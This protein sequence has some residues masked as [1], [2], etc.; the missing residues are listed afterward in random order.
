MLVI[1]QDSQFTTKWPRSLTL[2]STSWLALLFSAHCHLDCSKYSKPF[3]SPPLGF[4]HSPSISTVVSPKTL[5]PC[6][7][8]MHSSAYT[9]HIR[10]FQFFD[11]YFKKTPTCF[12]F[13][14]CRP[15]TLLSIPYTVLQMI[16]KPKDEPHNGWAPCPC[17]PSLQLSYLQTATPKSLSMESPSLLISLGQ[18]IWAPV[19]LKNSIRFEFQ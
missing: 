13:L 14:D 1:A 2:H 9:P 6:S 5:H 15:S 3:K 8:I 19:W 7:L 12:P 10:L 18:P 4:S 16:P 17:S 11:S